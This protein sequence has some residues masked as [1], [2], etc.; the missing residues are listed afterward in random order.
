MLVRMSTY[1]K[2][3]SKLIAYAWVAPNTALGLLL[4]LVM[5]SLG[6]KVQFIDGVAEFHGG[7]VGNFFASRSHPFCFGAITVGH[8]ILATCHNELSALRAHEHVHVRQYE[9]WGIF[10]LPAYALSS[11]WELCHGRNG[12]WNNCFEKQAY[13]EEAKQKLQA[14]ASSEI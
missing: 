1:Q 10:F 14:S 9:R 8:V 11:L 12:Y 4:G 13:A 7:W 2:I 3:I 6:G 5:I